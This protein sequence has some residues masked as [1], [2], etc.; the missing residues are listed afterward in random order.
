L[1]DTIEQ[2]EH[3]IANLKTPP[4]MQEQVLRI[5]VSTSVDTLVTN[6]P[7]SDRVKQNRGRLVVGCGCTFESVMAM[8][9]HDTGTNRP[10][11]D[12]WMEIMDKLQSRYAYFNDQQWPND[13]SIVERRGASH[14]PHPAEHLHA[15]TDCFMRIVRAL[16][17]KLQCNTAGISTFD[18][19]DESSMRDATKCL[20]AAIH[21]TTNLANHSCTPNLIKTYD[22]RWCISL[23]ISMCMHASVCAAR[24]QG[25]I[26]AGTELMVTYGPRFG[27][28]T[29]A[30]RQMKLIRAYG[31]ECDCTACTDDAYAQMEQCFLAYR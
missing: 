16:Y 4:T 23:V 18:Y 3:V 13:M 11:L 19:E 15:D 31:F 10:K 27:V 17:G 8:V 14:N 12:E 29:R 30:E 24:A 22:G 25:N 6:D 9:E 1:S 2:A 5:M 28:H 26:A 7:Q 20:P 21:V